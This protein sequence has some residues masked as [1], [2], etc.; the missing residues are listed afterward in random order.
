VLIFAIL[1]RTLSAKDLEEEE[2]EWDPAK[3]AKEPDP[4]K[5]NATEQ[6][7]GIIFLVL[8]LVLFNIYPQVLGFGFFAENDW[9]FIPGMLSEAFYDYLPWINL[10]F[11]VE[12]VSAVYLLRKGTWSVGTRIANIIINL[13]GILLAAIMLSGPALV[14]L[15]TEQLAETPLA[16][17]AEVL[18]WVAS[19]VPTL[20]LVGIIVV[21]GIETFQMSYQLIR[22]RK[23]APY[24]VI[25]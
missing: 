22:S 3:L 4:D 15:S 17:A 6:I 1:E 19:W 2:E 23:R 13:A 16:E 20:V 24:P 18:V 10:L 5:V 25:K 12:I 21:S 14:E 7:I 9:V 11:L 8:L